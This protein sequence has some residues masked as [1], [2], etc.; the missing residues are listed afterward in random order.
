MG[1]RNLPSLH[2]HRYQLVSEDD[3]AKAAGA[4]KVMVEG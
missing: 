4:K 1:E 2:R 3:F